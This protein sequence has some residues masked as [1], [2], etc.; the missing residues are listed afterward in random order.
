MLRSES[1][2][3]KGRKSKKKNTEPEKG[4]KSKREMSEEAGAKK[5]K[6]K[7]KRK[8]T[9]SSSSE[10]DSS[11]LS[12]SG[13]SST[14][15]SGESSS[16]SSSSEAGGGKK[17]KQKGKRKKRDVNWDL[18]NEMWPI[19]NRPKHLQRR[20]VVKKMELGQ[21]MRFKEHFEKEAERKGLG[22]AACGTDLKAKKVRYQAMSD[23]SFKKLHPARFNRQPL[24]APKK[25]WKDV[26]QK[27][28][29]ISRHFPLAH[30]GAEG[31]VNEATIVKMHDRQVAIELDMLAR[32]NFGKE[33]K[34]GERTAWT[35]ATEVRHIQEA[36]LNFA[37]L[38]HAIWPADYSGLVI[39][40]VLVDARWGAVVGDEEKKRVALIKRFFSDT[41]RENAGRAVRKEPPMDYEQTK[42]KWTRAVEAVFPQY[43]ALGG[44]MVVGGASGF[45][46]G[47]AGSSNSKQ[48][49]GQAAG[50]KFSKQKGGGGLQTP[51][52]VFNGVPVCYSYNSSM[53]CSRPKHGQNSCKDAKGAVFAHVCNWW[54]QKAT[55]HCF[56]VHPRVMNH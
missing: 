42:I 6:M 33:T 24:A 40:R 1:G 27:R 23:D 3:V 39:M 25:Y 55:K 2:L 43:N 37:T 8:E 19:N 48:G 32:C 29:E 4:K 52:A 54:D 13:D 30:Y 17:R 35:E 44:M 20:S 36:V 18:I 46:Q 15:S 10:T 53:G 47:K 22:A 56:L 38:Q 12:S 21:L 41:V 34:L 26:P 50:G 9:S 11:D 51:P 28:E 7:T 49:S 14:S 16:R 45:K 5:K 31:Q